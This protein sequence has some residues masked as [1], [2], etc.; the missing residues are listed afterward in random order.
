MGM[1]FWLRRY[2][3]T[4]AGPLVAEL[5]VLGLRAGAGSIAGDLDHVV[6]SRHGKGGKLVEISLRSRV[7]SGVAG[8]EVDA[9]FSNRIVVTQVRDAL[10]HHGDRVSIHHGHSA[11]DNGRLASR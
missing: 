1:L 2:S 9:S 7:Q 10:V 6:L 8:R 4:A 5:L 11:G 3:T